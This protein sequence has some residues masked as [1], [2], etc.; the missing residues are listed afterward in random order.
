MG[1]RLES[2]DRALVS[3]AAPRLSVTTRRSK[4]RLNSRPARSGRE[5]SRAVA[6]ACQPFH[7]WGEVTSAARKRLWP[8]GSR[9]TPW[10]STVRLDDGASARYELADQRRPSPTA[11]VAAA[12][13]A[14]V[15]ASVSAP[16]QQ[17]G[18][19]RQS[20]V[21]GAIAERELVARFAYQP[22]FFF[23]QNM[24]S[25]TEDTPQNVW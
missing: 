10:C 22:M 19:N 1:Q 24:K 6:A 12:T 7:G 11:T 18:G 14:S 2:Y 4:E 8:N 16:D 25:S 21:S 23:G 15:L 3:G 13:S 9:E 5:G 20:M 17:S